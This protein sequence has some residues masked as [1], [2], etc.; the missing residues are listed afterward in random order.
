MSEIDLQKFQRLAYIFET[1]FTSGA[2]IID[3]GVNIVPEATP[4]ELL[5]HEQEDE[6]EDDQALEEL[7]AA[8]EYEQLK[9][10]QEDIEEYIVSNDL[11]DTIGTELSGEGLLITIRQ[12]L[13]LILVVL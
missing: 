2:G 7:Q 11:I 13:H 3:E 1:E 10:I 6:Q 5:D 12:M 9:A 4:D 8:Q